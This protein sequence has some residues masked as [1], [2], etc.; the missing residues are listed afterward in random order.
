MTTK[1]SCWW[2]NDCA[3]GEKRHRYPEVPEEKKK[4]AEDAIFCPKLFFSFFSFVVMVRL[5][6]IRSISNL[7]GALTGKCRRPSHLTKF[8]ALSQSRNSVTTDFSESIF[9][10]P[11]L[12]GMALLLK[13]LVRFAP[14]FGASSYSVQNGFCTR[15]HSC[16]SV[17]K[18]FS[19]HTSFFN[20]TLLTV[21]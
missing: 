11:H 5:A 13:I 9:T 18:P 17:L 12:E 10:L 1:G 2:E 16:E 8:P 19:S 15:D 7:P 21:T 20:A 6:A 14:D 3:W 4:K